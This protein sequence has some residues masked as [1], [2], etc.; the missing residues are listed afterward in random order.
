MLVQPWAAYVSAKSKNKQACWDFLKFLTEPEN[1]RRITEMT[2]WVAG[3]YGG[4]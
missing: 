3:P 1:S 4:G 2:G